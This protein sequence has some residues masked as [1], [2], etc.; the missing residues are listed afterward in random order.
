MDAQAAFRFEIAGIPGA[1]GRTD[2]LRLILGKGLPEMEGA[3]EWC[4]LLVSNQRPPPCQG[5]VLPLN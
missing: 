5:G 3:E 4:A 2:L 1:V